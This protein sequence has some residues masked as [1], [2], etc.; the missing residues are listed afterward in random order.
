MRFIRK[1]DDVLEVIERSL[2]VLLFSALILSISFNIISRNLFH[3]SF[4]KILEVAPAMVLWLALIGSTLALKNKRHIKLEIL[5]RFCPTSFRYVAN[6]A[7]SLFGM[8]VMG[9]L[10]FA[11]L[12]FVKSEISI[13]GPWGWISIIFPIF[14]TL[15]FFRYL[16]RVLY[17]FE[18]TSDQV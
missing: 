1:I 18:G 15:C 2:V 10:V 4:Q 8:A 3:V 17:S 7:T 11:A 14:F 6:I 12:E 13:F 9:I 5:L 16:T